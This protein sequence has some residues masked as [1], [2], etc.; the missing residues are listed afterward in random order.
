VFFSC[1]YYNKWTGWVRKQKCILSK[2]GS[3]KP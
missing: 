2:S 1:G 3:H